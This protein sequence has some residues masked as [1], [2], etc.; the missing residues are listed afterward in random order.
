MAKTRKKMPQDAVLFKSESVRGDGT[1]VGP[2]WVRRKGKI[3]NYKD[4]D[5]LISGTKKF[6]AEWFT[7]GEARRL[8]RVL[9]LAFEEG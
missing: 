8:A 5:L 3:S 9:D 7:L 6:Y 2:V 1:I 4:S